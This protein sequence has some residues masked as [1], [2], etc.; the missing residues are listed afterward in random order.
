MENTN[1]ILN[2]I[3]NQSIKNVICVDD[4]FL[5][6]YEEILERDEKK[7][8]FSRQMYDA[9]S[10]SCE[11]AVTIVPYNQKAD[12]KVIKDKMRQK[13]LLILDWELTEVMDIEK[14]IEIIDSALSKNVQYICI[15]TNTHNLEGVCET[16]RLYYC[17]YSKSEVEYVAAQCEEQGLLKDEFVADIIDCFEKKNGNI[18]LLKDKAKELGVTLDIDGIGEND[19]SL[20]HKLYF[21]W[22]EKLLP[23]KSE[24]VASEKSDNSTVLN[25]GGRLVFVYGKS[26][27]EASEQINKVVPGNI[28]P[29]I[30]KYMVSEPNSILDALWLYYF[31]IFQDALYKRTEFFKNISS[32]A[33]F[34]HANKMLKEEGRD[35]LEDFFKESFKEEMT[36]RIDV[37]DIVIPE[38][39]LQMMV[40]KGEN[41]VTA[42]ILNELVK[43]NERL[44]VNRSLTNI[45]HNI[46]FGDLFRCINTNDGLSEFWLCITAKCDCRRPEKISNNYIFIGGDIC[47]DKRAVVEA[48]KQYFSYINIGTNEKEKMVAVEWNSKINSIYI[49]ENNVKRDSVIQGNIKGLQKEFKYICNVKENFAQRMANMAFADGNRVGISLAKM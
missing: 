42:N 28:I 19:K 17:G 14:P 45:C 11:C 39:I 18:K 7:H 12:V 15:Y 36:Q 48:E 34:Y 4:D 3:V 41:V 40:D 38:E 1:E 37:K 13:D 16:L 29:S 5:E 32:D 24:F 43:L 47:R 49:T 35:D 25:I 27:E 10:T 26:V 6:P 20:W 21:A 44:T 2:S 22:S 33:F 31:N 30:A 46:A 9:I 23:E 8:I